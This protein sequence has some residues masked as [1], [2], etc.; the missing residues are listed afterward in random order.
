MAQNQPTSAIVVVPSDTINIPNPGIVT[1]GNNIS[2]VATVLEDAAQ[3]FT[4]FT[5]NPNGYNITGGDV[6]VN[7]SGAIC[8]ILSV[9][10]ADPTKLNLAAPGL[11]AGAYEIFKGNYQITDGF[12][13]GYSLFV[14]N[15]GSLV[16]I[17]VQ[18]QTVPLF[19]IAN[20][21]WIPL[22][23]QRV[24]ATGTTCSDI[25]ALR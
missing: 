5:T 13:E 17:T 2:G 15:G 16:V 23:V 25:L 18:G 11:G 1:S 10:K 12:S 8:E 9:D 19:N 24:L 7:A 20:A 21:S 22:Q 14:G 3:D 6:V 4:N